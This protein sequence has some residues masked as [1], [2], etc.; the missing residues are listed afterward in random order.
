MNDS[1]LD[2]FAKTLEDKITLLQECQANK[3]VQTCSNC[4][5]FIGCEV[6]ASY[7]KAVYENL[8]KGQ[9]GGF[10]FN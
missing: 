7:V 1:M 6:R 4:E 9:Q 10:D 2:R 5:S 8:T 3:Q